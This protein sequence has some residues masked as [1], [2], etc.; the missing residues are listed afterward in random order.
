MQDF[1][2]FDLYSKK[3]KKG[4]GKQTRGLVEFKLEI[5]ADKFHRKLARSND[6]IVD[7]DVKALDVGSDMRHLAASDSLSEV[8][9]PRDSLWATLNPWRAGA[10]Q[11]Q[12][13][14]AAPDVNK[15]G[16]SESAKQ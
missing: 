1:G 13:P 7:E 15:T 16:S 3:N 10:S 9:T 11:P 6:T 2:S 8:K 14:E 5:V 12:K 4:N